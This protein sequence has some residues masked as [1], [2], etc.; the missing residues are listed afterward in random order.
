MYTVGPW[1]AQYYST[2]IEKS[3]GLIVDSSVTVPEV[4]AEPG[5]RKLTGQVDRLTQKQIHL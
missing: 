3:G 4:T 1:S 5:W 2:S